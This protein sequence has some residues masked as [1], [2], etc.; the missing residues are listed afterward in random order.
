MLSMSPCYR[1][2]A[3]T[4]ERAGEQH[5]QCVIVVKYRTRHAT[6]NSS[7]RYRRFFELAG[8]KVSQ[9]FFRR[10]VS[11][12]HGSSS[13]RSLKRFIANLIRDLTVPS[14][15]PNS[16]A[17]S[18]CGLSSIND[19]LMT[20]D[21][22]SDSRSIA[23]VTRTVSSSRETTTSADS[24]ASGVF[25]R[26]V[27]SL[28][29]PSRSRRRKES[30]LRLRAIVKMQAAAPVLAGSNLPAFRHTVT[31]GPFKAGDREATSRED[32]SDSGVQIRPL[33]AES[34]ANYLAGS[35]F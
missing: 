19:S 4:D 21:C 22:S 5:T 18:G 11:Y 27:S 25:A 12:G 24:A 31:D 30:I 35:I 33:C 20:L 8:R 15:M 23:A 10:M 9:K 7:Q 26:S 6:K 1:P 34:S 16:L 17:I 32:R 13:K 28:S 3:W 29:R 14:G 2:A